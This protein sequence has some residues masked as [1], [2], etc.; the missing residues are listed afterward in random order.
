MW[1]RWWEGTGTDPKFKVVAQ[2]SG[3]SVAV[4]LAVW[5]LLLEN[6]S[7]TQ[8]NAK[9]RGETSGNTIQDKNIQDKDQNIK[10]FVRSSERTD[11]NDE[12]EA[13]E[14]KNDEPKDLDP[15]AE[16]PPEDGG[17]RAN[18]DG[19]GIEYTAAFIEFWE[20]YPRRVRKKDAF[21]HWT[22]LI[23]KGAVV[24]EIVAAA[25]A[26]A[27]AMRYLERAPDKIM[28]PQTFIMTDRWR[29][30][31]PPEGQEYMDAQ[32]TYRRIHSARQ[33]RA[34]PSQSAAD[35]NRY[36]QYNEAIWDGSDFDGE[37]DVT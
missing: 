23:T 30:W 19:K 15:P 33:S 28:H 35:P 37:E 22:P 36:S 4:V 18:C 14:P 7:A 32:E 21:K 26:Y 16:K 34:Q 12:L 1:F 27:A 8:C 3:E 11:V 10:T 2:K 25:K 20:A 24:A 29:D 9:Q 6:A 17:A 5:A 13:I 31:L